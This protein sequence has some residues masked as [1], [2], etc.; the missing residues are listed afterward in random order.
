MLQTVKDA[1]N[2]LPKHF[3]LKEPV[4]VNRRKFSH[5]YETNEVLN[6]EPR[7]HSKRDIE[8]FELL[9]KDIESG[10]NKYLSVDSLKACILK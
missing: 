5:T 1:I 10:Q 3:P 6:H 2:D 8:I 4:Q 9:A 7:M